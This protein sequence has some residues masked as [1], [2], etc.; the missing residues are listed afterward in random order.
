MTRAIIR[1]AL[2]ATLTAAFALGCGG[3]SSGPASPSSPALP[4]SLVFTHSPIDPSVITKIVPLGNLNP[5]GHTLPTNHIYFY[6]ASSGVP[7]TAPA[8]GVVQVATRGADDALLVHAATGVSYD[9]GHIIL[10]GSITAGTSLTGGQRL[11]V[12]SSLSMALD[13]GVSNQAVTLFFVRPER[14]IPGTIHAD[15]PLKYFQEPTRSTLYAKV[16]RN[17]ADKDGKIDFDRAGRLSGNWFLEGLP[18][19]DTENVA[20]GPKHL[21]FVRD[22]EEP[23]LVRVGVGRIL[24]GRRHDGSGRHHVGYR[25]RQLPALHQSASRRHGDRAADRPDAR[26]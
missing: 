8:G 14:Y 17:S 20:N 26:G 6:R 25:R 2:A 13:L 23:S 16:A 15:S 22:V 10:D 9:L 1:G 11:G 19:A 12:T 18:V 21:A 7:V 24:C 4:A 3:G 5:P